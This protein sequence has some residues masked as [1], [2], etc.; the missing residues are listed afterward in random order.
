MPGAR[1]SEI[2]GVADGR[3]RVRLAAPA[4]DGRANRELRRFLGARLGVAPSAVALTQGETARRKVVHV[5][6]VD[7]GAA[8]RA[9]GLSPQAGADA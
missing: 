5:T 1:R 2:V 7:P 4:A 9:L 3:L 6:G 8:A